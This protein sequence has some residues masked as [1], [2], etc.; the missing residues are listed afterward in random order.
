MIDALVGKIIEIIT[1]ALLLE[2]LK[3]RYFNP[4]YV[5]TYFNDIIISILFRY[6]NT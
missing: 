3:K 1:D 4:K 2:L 5:T 6:N